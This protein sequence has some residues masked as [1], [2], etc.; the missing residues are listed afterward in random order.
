MRLPRAVVTGKEHPN[1]P[2]EVALI[3]SFRSRALRRY[4]LRGDPSKLPADRLR[5]I[6]TILDAM[7]GAVRPEQLDLPGFG[8]HRLVGDQK[9]RFAVSVSGNWR[10]TFDWNGEDAID[11]DFEDYH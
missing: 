5:R 1:P 7:E 6:D 10:I 8:F 11:V 9:G 3:Q 2:R 4:W